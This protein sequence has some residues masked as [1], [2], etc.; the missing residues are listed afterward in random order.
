VAL[1][2]AAAI[3]AALA[4][5]TD[6]KTKRQLR[7]DLNAAGNEMRKQ[8]RELSLSTRPADTRP[9]RIAGRYA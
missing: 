8:L 4:S 1:D 6:H 7:A 5:E 9:P 3:T 2:Q